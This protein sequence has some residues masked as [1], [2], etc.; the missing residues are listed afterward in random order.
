MSQS[1]YSGPVNSNW[2]VDVDAYNGSEATFFTFPDNVSS[3]N[4][5]DMTGEILV[6]GVVVKSASAKGQG[7]SFS[8]AA[9]VN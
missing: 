8:L 4:N 3:I 1:V 7:A 5:I 9:G 6:E 2:S